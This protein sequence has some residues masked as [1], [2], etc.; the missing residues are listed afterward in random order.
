MGVPE[1]IPS[2]SVEDYRSWEGD[3]ELWSG[4]PVAMSPSPSSEHSRISGEMIFRL[5]TALNESGCPNCEVYPELDWVVDEQTVVRPVIAVACGKVGSQA[6]DAA[7][8]LIIEILSPS[9]RDL[10]LNQ[11]RELYAREGVRHYLVVDPEERSVKRWNDSWTGL[12]ERIDIELDANCKI[13][14]PLD[15]LFSSPA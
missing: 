14:L 13:V 7:P 6:L 1:Y 15:A 3:W 2:Y 5:K 9:T 11:R 8:A 4:I 12:E 10:D